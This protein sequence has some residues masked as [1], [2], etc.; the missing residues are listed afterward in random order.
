M[1]NSFNSIDRLVEFGLG[2][3]IAQQ[4]IRTM[5]HAMANM[6]VA[7]VGNAFASPEALL[8]YAV[9]DNIQIGPLSEN[10]ITELIKNKSI[11][12]N[13]L[14]WKVGTSAWKIAESI[15]EINKLILLNQ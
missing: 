10:E 4:M 3:G 7:G 6:S 9:V 13:T 2:I 11:Y 8:F 12:R 5:N 1:E 14:M 15:P